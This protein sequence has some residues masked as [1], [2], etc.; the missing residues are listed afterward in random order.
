MTKKLLLTLLPLLLITACG[1]SSNDEPP[2]NYNEVIKT[3]TFLN[4]GKTGTLSQDNKVD[5]FVAFFNNGNDLIDT[6]EYEGFSQIQNIND[7]HTLCLGSGSTNGLLNFK[8]NYL[9]AK[10]TLQ[11]QAYNKYVAY[12][13]TWNI[14]QESVLTVNGNNTIDLSTTITDQEPPVHTIDITFESKDKVQNLKFEND[15]AQHR[16]F[17]H[18]IDITYLVSTNK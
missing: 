4:C 6:Y 16:V 8:F 10:V 15:A 18:Q 9:L 12:T 17:I 14:D 3:I 11:L 2:V 1:G 7:F 13:D 5:E